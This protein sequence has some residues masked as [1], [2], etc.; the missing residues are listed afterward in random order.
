MIS[1]VMKPKATK[2]KTTKPK[3]TKRK[4]TKKVGGGK[5]EKPRPTISGPT[6]FRVVKSMTVASPKLPKIAKFEPISD[7]FVS[8]A[9]KMRFYK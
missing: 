7:V 6:N 2:R 5:T 8:K 1:K 4:T 3:T 9:D